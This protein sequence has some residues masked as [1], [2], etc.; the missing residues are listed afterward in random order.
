M[1]ITTHKYADF[2]CKATVYGWI[3]NQKELKRLNVTLAVQHL[4]IAYYFHGEHLS[5]HG[6]N[7]TLNKARNI[8]KG[9]TD[10]P[11]INTVYGNKRISLHDTSIEEYEWTFK[12]SQSINYQNMECKDSK[13][14]Q[15][16]K[17]LGYN[18]K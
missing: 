12:A 14:A 3:R 15:M 8:A 5:I 10:I 4:C 7:I 11:S 2:R 13:I 1:S 18:Q 9:T 6:D 17:W 16:Q